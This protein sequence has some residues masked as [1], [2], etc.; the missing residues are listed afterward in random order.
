MRQ[1]LEGRCQCFGRNACR[2]SRE[3]GDSRTA[4]RLGAHD[5]TEGGKTIGDRQ[6]AQCRERQGPRVKTPSPPQDDADRTADHD[7]RREDR[8][9]E[10][11][12]S[13]RRAQRSGITAGGQQADCDP[14]ARDSEEG[15]ED[16]RRKEGAGGQHVAD[17]G[18]ASRGAVPR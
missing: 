11:H 8:K 10:E 17:A 13:F 2:P 7:D 9:S 3:H 6:E 5:R 15:D 1:E 18:S 14:V 12:C 16:A 4:D